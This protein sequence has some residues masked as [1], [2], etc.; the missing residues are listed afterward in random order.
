MT[1][2]YVF[3]VCWREG[4]GGGGGG[5]GEVPRKLTTRIRRVRELIRGNIDAR[6]C[7]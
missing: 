1:L 3:F 5:D 2:N 4:G 6:G 7:I